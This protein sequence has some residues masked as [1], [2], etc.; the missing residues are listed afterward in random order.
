LASLDESASYF[1]EKI[2]FDIFKKSINDL[3]FSESRSGDF[4]TGSVTFS[5]LI[6]MRSL[7]F[8]VVAVLGLDNKKFPRKHVE[9][10]FNLMN[11]RHHLGDRNIKDND[12][13]LFLET[14]L[15]AD[16]YLYLSYIGH[17]TKD[18]AEIPP[19]L[20]IDE[21]INYVEDAFEG[22]AEEVK[23]ILVTHHPLH[24]F[25]HR[26]N[27]EKDRKLYSFSHDEIKSVKEIK[28]IKR[29]EEEHD[30]S[31]ITLDELIWFFK[32]PFK[33]YYNK[34][35]KI[36]FKEEEVLLPEF[37]KFDLDN[38]D[39]YLVKTT[40]LNT[41]D[42]T[43]TN[44]FI[45]KEKK[46]GGLPLANMAEVTF[47]AVA[48]ELKHVKDILDDY[49]EGASEEKVNISIQ[50]EGMGIEGIVHDIYNNR[51]LSYSL[52][53]KN[54]GKNLKSPK[55]RTRKYILEAWIKHIALIASGQEKDTLFAWNFDEDAVTIPA[56]I[57][58][59]SEAKK[60]LFKWIEIFIKGHREI[61]PFDPAV[62]FN[63]VYY[64]DNIDKSFSELRKIGETGF[65]KDFYDDY[66]KMEIEKEYFD[67]DTSGYQE[68]LD[69][70][71]TVSETVW[72]PLF[73][74]GK[75]LK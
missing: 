56:N 69:T 19:S 5:S 65:N 3:L 12:K 31:T 14:L 38:L 11:A 40:I 55:K 28:E 52:S 62:G 71:Q 42:D 13:H 7:P 36:Y 9:P 2:G 17:A 59:Q 75:I 64:G 10:E 57:I 66:Y 25:S 4:I 49:K 37:E 39:K 22:D 16:E 73:N 23:K 26:Y 32:N 27:T 61:I 58:P 15:A 72:N 74:N 63:I 33:W 18:N 41:S 53:G 70:L 43:D 6:P 60:L 50:L 48:E 21:L 54:T 44:A 30:F 1:D 67:E 24:S 20:L 47:E 45:D 34:T 8:K 46:T 68:K 35:L 51:C 29:K